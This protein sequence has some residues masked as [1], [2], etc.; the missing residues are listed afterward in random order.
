[1]VT[2]DVVAVQKLL[3]IDFFLLFFDALDLLL[4]LFAANKLREGAAVSVVL[5]CDEFGSAGCEVVINRGVG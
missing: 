3:I 1:M 5:L 4:F 2:F